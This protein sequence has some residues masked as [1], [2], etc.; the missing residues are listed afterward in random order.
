M[1]FQIATKKLSKSDN[2]KTNNLFTLLIGLLA[3]IMVQEKLYAQAIP[4]S[5]GYNPVQFNTGICAQTT[6]P[7]L[8]WW[9]IPFGQNDP[10]WK[11]DGS[12]GGPGTTAAVVGT[13]PT[14]CGWNNALPGFPYSRWITAPFNNCGNPSSSYS[15]AAG[16]PIWFFKRSFFLPANSVFMV[17]W[18]IFASGWVEAIRVNGIT[19]YTASYTLPNTPNN[20]NNPVSFSWCWNWNYGGMNTV[21]IEVRNNGSTPNA[22]KNT[23]LL[24]ESWSLPTN[25]YPTMTSPILACASYSNLLTIPTGPGTYSWTLPTTWGGSSS[26]YTLSAITGSLSGIVYGAKVAAGSPKKCLSISGF[27]V[28]VPPPLTITATSTNVCKGTPVTLT[29]SGAITYTWSGPNPVVPGTI[30][31][32]AAITVTPM[33]STTYTLKGNTPLGNCLYTKIVTVVVK[34]SP[35]LTVT[36]NTNQICQGNSA[37]LQASGNSQLPY[38]WFTVPSTT[39]STGH[40]LTVTPNVTSTYIGMAQFFNGCTTTLA[41][42][43]PVLPKPNITASAAPTVVCAGDQATLSATGGTNY[44]WLPVGLSGSPLLVNPGSSTNYTVIGTGANGCTNSAV[45]SV[46]VL[47]A[48]TLTI[49]PPQ[50]CS[51]ISNTLTASGAMNNVYTWKIGN[52]PNQTIIT[53]TNTIILNPTS[54]TPYTVCATAGN[55]CVACINGTLTLGTPIVISAPDVTLCTNAGSCTTLSVSSTP[56]TNVNY[57]W[58]PSGQ[59]GS[60]VTVCPT[61]NTVYNVSASSPSV[62]C[63]NS[64]TMAVIIASNCCTQPTIGLTSL[65]PANGIGGSYSNT[66]YILD[67]STTLTSS[68]Y[69]A[70]SEVW[71]TPGVSITVPSGMQLDLETTHLFACGQNM[72][73]GIIIQDGGRITTLNTRLGN[74]MI[75][76]A[77]VAIQLDNISLTNS[78]PNPPIDI[79]RIIFNRNLIGIQISNSDPG[80]THLPLGIT[81]CIFS[82]RTMPFTTFPVTPTWPNADM[83]ILPGAL[84]WPAAN[85]PT[86][87]LASPYSFFGWLP[88]TLKAPYSNQPG[89]IG[90][91]IFNIGNPNG[92]LPTPGVDIGVTYPGAITNDFNLFDNIGVG[93]EILNSSLTTKNNVFQNQV[94][95]SSTLSPS[96]TFGGIGIKHD[97]TT[98]MNAR[99]DL[100]NSNSA[101][102]GNRFW[103]CHTGI[104]VNNVYDCWVRYGIFRSTHSV[105]TA[106]NN[107]PQSGDAGVD[108]TTN[109]FDFTVTES[110]FNNLRNG[111]IFNTPSVTMNYVVSATS[112]LSGV[113]VRG[114]N[115]ERN[116][117]GALVTSTAPYSLGNANTSEYMSDA[118]QLNTP[119]T[120]GWAYQPNTNILSYIISNKINRSFRGISI[121]GME[122]A[123]LAI[124]ENTVLIED[125]FTFGPGPGQPAFGFGIS[126]INNKDNLS[127]TNNTLETQ[128]WHA[129]TPNPTVSLIYLKNNDATVFN[130]PRVECNSVKNSYYG[131]QFDGANRNMV[132]EGNEMCT[133]WSGMALTHDGTNEGEIG[134]QGSPNLASGNIWSTNTFQCAVWFFSPNAPNQTYCENSNPNNSF[135]YVRNGS[136]ADVPIHNVNNLGSLYPPYSL[137]PSIDDQPVSNRLNDCLG[138]TSYLSPPN[139]RQATVLDSPDLNDEEI[140]I[141]PNP[142]NTMFHLFYSN[143]SLNYDVKIIDLSGKIVLEMNSVSSA[144]SINISNLPASLYFVLLKDQYSRT[145]R[146]KLI[147]TQ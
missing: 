67:A 40:F 63:P 57:T 82:S 32:N 83:S 119:N 128:P 97:I 71:I 122:N 39:I 132:W 53:G 68:A 113:C 56:S 114:I 95:F 126:V 80:I 107:T 55:S 79:Q 4:P 145:K 85:T 84:R 137:G 58:Q 76:D 92:I 86:T 142:T 78:S 62:G 112:T 88:S 9:G 111:I 18:R 41:I 125:D 104:L 44:V 134:T 94:S 19:T 130:S 77:V 121:N 6:T 16:T 49:N 21:E 72:W 73:Q 43:V 89:H 13:T 28:T 120:A 110:Q 90:I 102:E 30:S 54:S 105:N 146:L 14:A 117:F 61:V 91:K 69:F 129:V 5:T 87:G 22:C 52:P 136:P 11:V 106:L 138:N 74:S 10:N 17:N 33:V 48:P 36:S 42:T 131:F 123:P 24:V 37:V 50:I 144:S 70:N 46:S 100:T 12:S 1:K 139:W 23:A 3:L 59:T 60:I 31:N 99:L 116:Y 143:Y 98:L 25:P 101:S 66:S 141:F 75:E 109:R 64:T 115:I 26:N 20:A 96:G 140:L 51:G 81:G 124:A 29:G 15:C 108:I 35:F 118:I 2:R 103:N 47:V 133:H 127:I 38:V 34:P 93:I 147:K 27:N 7:Q 135:L 8:T 45:A 65:N